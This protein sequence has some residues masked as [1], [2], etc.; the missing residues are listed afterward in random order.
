MDNSIMYKFISDTTFISIHNNLMVVE[1]EEKLMHF[2]DINELIDNLD[3]YFNQNG[4]DYEKLMIFIRVAFGESKYDSKCYKVGDLIG[5]S[6]YETVGVESNIP[7]D[8]D[9]KMTYCKNR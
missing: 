1:P 2:D 7:S 9:I 8:Y 6:R 3:F 5:P 4:K